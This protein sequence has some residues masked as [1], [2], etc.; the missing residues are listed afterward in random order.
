MAQAEVALLKPAKYTALQDFLIHLINYFVSDN[1]E[2][3]YLPGFQRYSH[4]LPGM[5]YYRNL[6]SKCAVHWFVIYLIN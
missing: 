3:R 2:T 6:L 4:W 1:P 5:S